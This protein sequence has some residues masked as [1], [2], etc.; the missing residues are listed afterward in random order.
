MLNLCTLRNLKTF[1]LDAVIAQHQ[2]PNIQ[3][4]LI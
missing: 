3:H 4:Y 1:R 2:I